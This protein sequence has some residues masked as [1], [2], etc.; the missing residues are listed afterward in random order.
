METHCIDFLISSFVIYVCN[1]HQESSNFNDLWPYDHNELSLSHA[2]LKPRS[3]T[4][5]LFNTAH[6]SD[7]RKETTV[8]LDKKNA[9]AVT[10]SIH[11]LTLAV[12]KHIEGVMEINGAREFSPAT[13]L[14]LRD[15]PA[16]TLA[17]DAVSTCTLPTPAIKKGTPSVRWEGSLCELWRRAA[18]VGGFGTGGTTVAEYL[19]PG[20]GIYV[21]CSNI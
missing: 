6:T 15:S 17:A 2:H 16:V 13:L 20:A 19:E 5:N 21:H 3:I 18:R 12:I 14:Q 4:S 9:A 11:D 8:P 7:K 10:T 1:H